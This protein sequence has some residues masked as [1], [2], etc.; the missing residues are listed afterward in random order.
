MP[1]R[2][3]Y[4]YDKMVDRDFI[5][6]VIQ[7]AA[8]GRRSR[9]DIAPVLA[10][11]DGYVEKT[12]E[13][14][15]TE[16][17]VPSEPK[18]REIYDESSEK[19]RKIKMVPFWPDGVIQWMLVTAMKPVLMRGMH[20][21]SCASIPGRGG[22]RIHKMIRGA[23]RNDP[24]GTKYAAELDVAQYYPS[25]S[26]K[27]LI[28]ALARKI[29]DKRF[30]RTVY[31]IIESCSGGLAIGYYI[32]QW[33]ANFYLEPLDQYIM[34]LPGV[35]YMTRYMDNITLLG[36]NKK[37]LHKARKLIAA[38][39]QQRLGLSMKANWQIYP[40]AKR[41]V[42]AVGYRFSRTHVILRKRNFLRFTRQCRRVKKRLDAGKPIMFAQASGLLS[43]AGQLKHCNSHTI[44]VKYIDLIGVKHLKEVVRN[45]SKRRQRAQQRFL[46][47]GAA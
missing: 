35:K 29:K 11:L 27:R 25:I 4:L 34:T 45:E 24:K 23:L 42:S 8:K 30:L 6:A 26:G 18:I 9:K 20:P 15:A 46:A 19:H 36:P 39:M 1:K 5:R 7:E 44:R 3:G 41:M 38:F 21:W 43:R 28:W 14:V 22:K 40:T 33:L 31:S 47:G 17:F 10:D 2:V 13:L 12:Y 37:Q 16:S 32:C